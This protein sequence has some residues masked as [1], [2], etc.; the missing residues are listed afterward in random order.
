MLACNV[1]ETIP[2]L[3]REL[4]TVFHHLQRAVLKRFQTPASP[5]AETRPRTE[6]HYMSV[7]YTSVS[8]FL[9]LRLFC[10]AILNPKLFGLA[11]DFPDAKTART[12]TLL[13]KTLQCLANLAA[14]GV[15]EPY[16]LDMNAFIMV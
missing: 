2:A 3:S 10:P 4:R 12:L 8:G 16:M 1:F 14:F 7:R 11:R 13:A 6:D 9:F 5:S 15:K